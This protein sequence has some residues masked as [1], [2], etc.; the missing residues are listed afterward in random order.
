MH[1]RLEALWPWAVGLGGPF[2]FSVCSFGFLTDFPD[3]D[4]TLSTAG[5]HGNQRVV[6]LSCCQFLLDR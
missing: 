5:R 4:T 1:G 2:L 3:S 6:T